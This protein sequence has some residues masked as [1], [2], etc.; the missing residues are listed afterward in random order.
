MRKLFPAI[1]IIICIIVFKFSGIE[2]S[3]AAAQK[4]KTPSPIAFQI[5]DN[6]IISPVS[7]LGIDLVRR[8]TE[9][10]LQYSSNILMDPGFEGKLERVIV[11]V[12]RLTQNSF[13]DEAGLGYPDNYWNEAEFDV[14]SGKSAGKNGVIKTSLNSGEEGLPQYFSQNPLPSLQEGDVIVLTKSNR[15]DTVPNWW[16]SDPVHVQL[17]PYNNKDNSPGNQSI[18]L[19]SS[20]NSVAHMKFFSDTIAERSG[21]ML[22]VNGSWKLSFW[23]K[24]ERPDGRIDFIFQRKNQS[25]PFLKKTVAISTRWE[26]HKIEFEAKDTEAPGFLELSIAA[27][28]PNNSIWIDDIFLGANNNGELVFR[29]E[30]IDALKALKPS[31]LREFPSPGN[32]WENHIAPPA[33]RK[34]WVSFTIGNPSQNIFNYSLTEFLDL[35]QLVGANPWIIIPP[36]FSDYECSQMGTF[37]AENAP[38]SKFSEIILEFG[39]ENWN[40]MNRPLAIPYQKEYGFV[41]DRAFDVISKAVNKRSNLKFLV[42]GEYTFSEDSFKY[43]NFSKLATGMAVAPYFFKSLQKA[44]PD[45]E[46]LE[47][48]FNGTDADLMSFFSDELFS[49]GKSLAISEINL[50]ATQGDAKS[51]ERNRVVSGA[52]SGSAL[53]K[54][55]LEALSAGADPIMV[56]NIGQYDTTTWEIGDYVNLW[57]IIRDYGPP[58][59]FR[60]TGL[61][62]VML[63]QVI[64]GNLYATKLLNPPSKETNALTL[65]P[66]KSNSGWTVAI[67]SSSPKALD[68]EIHFPNDNQILPDTTLKL[69]TSDPFAT[70]ESGEIVKIIQEKTSIDG[71]VVQTTIPAWG[72]VVL[73][74]AEKQQQE[75]NLKKVR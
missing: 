4:D 35:C 37:L 43:L 70:N 47:R 64:G 53:A 24:A 41:A 25:I 69:D 15:F 12:S 23:A 27:A 32:T 73:K 39:S 72:L 54:K 38:K 13:S 66:F 62:V 21:N 34:S 55:I 40:W 30:L 29:K 61:A 17:D 49:K 46:I 50:H 52:A 9:G 75:A 26:E 57:G 1:L 6:I 36:T 67:V 16:V 42:N 45:E 58:L 65:A 11:I 71:R 33:K 3:L 68:I 2:N 63:N 19:R 14:R 44:T 56:H 28:T 18:K 8:T 5:E 59:L 10:A 7:R 48:L 60:P 22:S 51:Y 74:Q 20:K 31:Y